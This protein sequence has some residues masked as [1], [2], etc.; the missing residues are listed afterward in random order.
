MGECVGWRCGLILSVFAGAQVD[1]AKGAGSSPLGRTQQS[2]PGARA[3]PPAPTQKIAAAKAPARSMS[4][5]PE[6]GSGAAKTGPKLSGMG[7]P[8]RPP[9]GAAAAR[10]AVGAPASEGPRVKTPHHRVLP[11]SPR[12]SKPADSSEA[13]DKSDAKATGTASEQPARPTPSPSPSPHPSDGKSIDSF[14]MNEFL[15]EEQAAKQSEEAV[16][17]AGAVERQ[18]IPTSFPFKYDDC[19]VAGNISTPG[20]VRFF[21]P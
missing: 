1:A 9:T 16:V 8:P 21:G 5:L 7:T 13:G 12:V 11:A 3:T 18:D 17:K 10:P 2:A 14:V 6:T 20:H 4:A 19:V 15:A